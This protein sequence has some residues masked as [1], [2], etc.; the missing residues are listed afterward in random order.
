[1][2][3]IIK[4]GIMREEQLLLPLVHPVERLIRATDATLSQFEHE[5]GRESVWPAPRAGLAEH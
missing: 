5:H 4:L 3:K 2:G 1:L